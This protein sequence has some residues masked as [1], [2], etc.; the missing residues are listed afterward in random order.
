MRIIFGLMF[1]TQFCHATPR[2]DK[3]LLRQRAMTCYHAGF[4][5]AMLGGKYALSAAAPSA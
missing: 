3:D 1:S 2:A 4:E 5:M